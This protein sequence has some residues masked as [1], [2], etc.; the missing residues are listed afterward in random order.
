MRFQLKKQMAFL[1]TVTIIAAQFPYAALAGTEAAD[2]KTVASFS[3]LR[4][5]IKKQTVP[6]GTEQE[7]LILPDQLEA[8]IIVWK[9]EKP[10]IATPSQ[11]KE[12]GIID[13]K[14]LKEEG[15]TADSVHTAWIPVT[16]D[17]E[18]E[19]DGDTEGRY[20]F[21][22]DIGDYMLADSVKPPQIAVTV[23]NSK[24][25]PPDAD[26]KTYQKTYTVDFSIGGYGIT[27]LSDNL[28]FGEAEAG[29]RP[30]S[31][32][33]D[34]GFEN[35]G[36]LP[37][38]VT[39]GFLLEAK[40]FEVVNHPM[41]TVL[42]A[43]GE[44]ISYSI[45]PKSG[46]AP[47]VYKDTFT[48]HTNEG[49]IAAVDLKFTVTE[50]ITQT[51]TVTFD[52]AGGTRTGGGELTQAVLAG[53]AAVAPEVTRDGYTFTGWDK[54]FT[55][56]AADMTVTALWEENGFYGIEPLSANLD[57]GKTETGYLPSFAE[58]TVSFENTGTLPLNVTGGILS[59]AEAFEVVN[60]PTKTVLLAAGETTS[61]SIQPKSG[62]EP[63]VYKDTFTVYT[64]EGV[65]AAVNL[66]FTVTEKIIQT[67]TVTFDPAGGTRTGGGELTQAVPAGG[68]AAA[69]EVTRG[70]YTF[71]GWDK[72][73]TNVSADMTVT[74]LWKKNAD[75]SDREDESSS[76][77][78]SP[79]IGKISSEDT[80]VLYG[81]WEQ[82]AAGVWMFR[83]SN[84][85]YA[86]S[87]W[88]QVNGQWYYFDAEGK[89][90]T[91]WYYDPNYQKW[92][93]L[94]PN[95]GM[96]VGW[97]QINGKWYYF[98]P[99]SDGTKGAMAAGTEVDG[100]PIGEDGA[101]IN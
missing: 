4:D 43:A 46:L 85:S 37:L 1:L 101:V 3:V 26:A 100:Y 86:K 12:I 66:T 84:G 18:P 42:L 74:A 11:A 16:W 29:Y 52:P 77:N 58:K 96:A 40:A 87:T 64:A 8:E 23:E 2:I 95:G 65:T 75:S 50:K 32:A 63:G 70:G 94:E 19:Y 28:D 89:M 51:V 91:D 92:F 67:V 76:D 56:V 93:Y 17:S 5:D 34:V 62:L 48:V 39:G 41:K 35:T 38:N 13:E 6:V 71:T 80:S 88:G 20:V 79:D 21:T 53:G 44:T 57:F 83:M 31:A 98:N 9:E 68:G 81:N 99:V 61:Y 10:D 97:R 22:A 78:S 90:L 69:P 14:N 45:Q 72:D 30:S 82:T 27:P 24:F 36:T 7:D 15:S 49:F 54:D 33:K 60:P 25:L 55:N 47:G 73:F 59:K